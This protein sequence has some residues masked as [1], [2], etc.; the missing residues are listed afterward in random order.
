MA[1]PR[2]RNRWTYGGPLNPGGRPLSP[3]GSRRWSTTKGEVFVKVAEPNPYP[4]RQRD[5]GRPTRCGWWRPLRAVNWERQHGP[6]PAGC[7]VWRLLPV[8][9]CLD[10]LV[11]V[12]RAVRATLNSGRW[13]R[14]WRPWRSLPE[15]R[16]LRLAAVAAAV[17]IHLARERERHLTRPCECECG[18]VI[19]RYDRFGNERFYA[20][21]HNSLHLKRRTEWRRSESRSSESSS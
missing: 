11:L 17:A 3:V 10:N 9:D 21:G 13:C 16:D 4:S 15:D 7:V 20:H 14:P 18:T 2:K 1:W 12:S 6:V 8:C 19:P 5:D